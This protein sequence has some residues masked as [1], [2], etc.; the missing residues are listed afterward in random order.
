[1]SQTIL[2]QQ[3]VS[4]FQR[5]NG[6]EMD[7]QEELIQD[8]LQSFPLA[9]VPGLPRT[10]SAICEDYNVAEPALPARISNPAI[11]RANVDGHVASPTNR[12]FSQALQAA[13]QSHLEAARS[14]S[15]TA[16]SFSGERSP[17]RTNSMM[18]AGAYEPSTSPGPRMNTAAQLREQQQRAEATAFA[19]ANAARRTSRESSQTVSPKE[20]SKE[21]DQQAE[22]DS[23]GVMFSSLPNSPRH[24]LTKARP[25]RLNQELT[26]SSTY[27][28]L[29][30]GEESPNASNISGHQSVPVPQQYP[31]IRT[32]QPPGL[33]L[34]ESSQESN[35]RFPATMISMESTLSGSKSSAPPSPEVS[36]YQKENG[37][38]DEDEEVD[39]EEDS[40]VEEE[41]EKTTPQRPG[42]T[43]SD[44]GTYT[45]TYH[46]CTQRFETPQKLQKHKKEGHRQGTP[47][48]NADS[49]LTQA[50]PHK[51][52]RTNPQTGKPCNSI[53]SRPY[54]LTRHEDTIHNARK[55][56]VR[57]RYC[58]EEKTFSRNDALTRHMRVVHPD[59]EFSGKSKRGSR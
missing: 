21:Y 16:T 55:Q 13:N 6:H 44:G 27:E 47:S 39:E 32:H 30:N 35:P 15:P 8:K 57:C 5:Q 59:I 1:M 36:P 45:C 22:N 29:S 3:Q 51:C 46:G 40:E 56:K 43:R 31:F 41:D 12:A 14:A 24:V 42:N 54:D 17:F 23:Q 49:R 33:S 10:I 38:E 20:V 58:T 26:R 11:S 2:Q 7:Q 18:S 50:G 19:L 48:S 25:S 28:Q 4:Q 53:F 9:K 37:E 52:E 34:P